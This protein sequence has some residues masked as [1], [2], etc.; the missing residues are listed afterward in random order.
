MAVVTLRTAVRNGA[1]RNATL[2]G[3]VLLGPDG[4]AFFFR[5]N[6]VLAKK[7]PYPRPGRK[8]ARAGSL[9]I[10]A[11]ACQRGEEGDS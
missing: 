1:T 9:R 5:R 8:R 10:R 7:S 2:R 3:A 6:L 11:G 4:Q